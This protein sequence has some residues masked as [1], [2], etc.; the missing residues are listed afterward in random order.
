MNISDTL[1][2]SKPCTENRLEKENKV[3][4]LLDKLS[5]PY[6]G[7][8][9][10]EAA[11]IELCKEIEKK[12]GAEICKNL[13]LC[14]SQKTAFYLLLMPGD[15]KF[16]TKDLSKKINS[17]RLSF[18]GAEHMESLLNITPGSVSVL[19]LMNDSEKQVKLLIDKD[20]LTQEYIGCHPCINT[21]TL[22]IKL[23]D[24]QEKLLPHLGYEATIVDLPVVEE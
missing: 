1:F 15:K 2:T 19:G 17:A 14:N 21:S 24:I 7:I 9:H 23:S 11:T 6:S 5:I 20:L 13:F 3:Y 4:E 16:K 18:A 10:D 8:D 12:L 22:K